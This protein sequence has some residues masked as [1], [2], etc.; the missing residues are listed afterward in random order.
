MRET[1][2]VLALGK[3]QGKSLLRCVAGLD[4]GVVRF[5]S[6]AFLSTSVRALAGAVGMANRH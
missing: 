1:S 3:P 6:I 2:S 5:E 4:V